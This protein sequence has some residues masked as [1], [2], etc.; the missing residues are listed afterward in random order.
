MSCLLCGEG[1][2]TFR[3]PPRPLPPTG[4]G[5]AGSRPLSA[6]STTPREP[7]AEPAEARAPQLQLRMETPAGVA[8]RA[9]L[10]AAEAEAQAGAGDGDEWD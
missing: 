5:V 4:S 8:R 6:A 1:T 7:A 10:A 3:H 9:A 2:D